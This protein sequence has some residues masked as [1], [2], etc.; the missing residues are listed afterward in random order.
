M[1]NSTRLAALGG[2]A[3]AGALA[4]TACGTDNNGGKSSTGGGTAASGDCVKT[5]V[6]AAGST[7]Q[8]NAISEWTKG[9]QQNCAGANLNYNANGSG[10]GIQAFTQGQVAFAGSDSALKPEEHGPADARCKTG[11]ALD[12]PMVVGPIAVVYNLKGVDGLQL[13]PTTLASI[14]AGKIKTWDD[15]AIKKDNPQAKLPSTPI[16]TVHRADDSGTTDNFTKF[17]TATAPDIWKFAGGKKWTAPGGQG[18]TK[19]DGV[20]TVV[21]QTDGAI[22]YAELSYAT[23]GK[24]QSAKI[25]NGSGQFVE[26]SSDTA[27]K[28]AGGATIAGT[29]NDL[30][31]KID[32]KTK[33]GYPIV[34]VTYEVVC[35][36]GLP[37]QQAKFVKSYLTYTSSQQGQSV[38]SGLGYAPL[39]DSI[40]TKVQATVKGLS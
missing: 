7:A 37:D 19:S 6:N 33:D 30:A 29:G 20:S 39:P 21:K 4:L 15:A 17:L 40:L 2:V 38:L 24:L 31:L 13:S 10:A 3:L 5:T 28:G 14:F 12:L 25:A 16:K 9:Y 34:L 22:A 23:N 18:A 8:A 35:E 26:A 36:K 27:S 11:K 1:I 32:Y